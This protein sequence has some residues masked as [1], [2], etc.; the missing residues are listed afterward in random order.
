[1][2][3]PTARSD[4][5]RGGRGI[6]KNWFPLLVSESEYLCVPLGRP[7]TGSGCQQGEK[8]I[9]DS[10][11]CAPGFGRRTE[12]AEP[13]ELRRFIHLIFKAPRA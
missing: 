11:T 9:L 1:M 5:P 2:L 8:T 4:E 6:T 7:G 3:S 13:F 12:L 10:L